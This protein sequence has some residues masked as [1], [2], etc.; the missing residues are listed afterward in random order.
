VAEHLAHAYGEM[1]GA[2]PVVARERRQGVVEHLDVRI[3]G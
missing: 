3:V 2:Q 1:L